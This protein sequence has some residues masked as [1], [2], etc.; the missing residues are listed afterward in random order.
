MALRLP[1]TSTRFDETFPNAYAR[2]VTVSATRQRGGGHSVMIDVAAYIKP[3]SSD[4]VQDLGLLRYH[5]PFADL[6]AGANLLIQC[7]N[8][9]KAHPDFAVAT[10]D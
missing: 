10:D 9:L 4:D 7:Y 1:F 5:T 8:W 2:I 6:P 3:P